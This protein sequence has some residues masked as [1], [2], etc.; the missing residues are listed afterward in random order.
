[1][2]SHPPYKAVRDLA[3][4]GLCSLGLQCALPCSAWPRLTDY[5]Q[6]IFQAHCAL[7]TLSRKL[8]MCFPPFLNRASPLFNRSPPTHLS[9]LIS[10]RFL[11]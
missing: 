3:A 1:M 10:W 6:F 11:G 7:F 8:S 4:A 5:L 2:K 9:D